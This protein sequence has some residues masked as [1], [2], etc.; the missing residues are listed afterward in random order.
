MRL[1]CS[2]DRLKF[3]SEET[4]LVSVADWLAENLTAGAILL[5]PTTPQVAFPVGTPAPINQADFT[6]PAN[7][8]ARPALS[9]PLGHDARAR[10]FGLQLLGAPDDLHTLFDTAHAIDRMVNAYRPPGLYYPPRH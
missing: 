9:I 4:L 1:A 5:T 8:A 2:R 10:P 6:A 7:I 3:E